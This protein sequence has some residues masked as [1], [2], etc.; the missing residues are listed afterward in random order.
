MADKIPKGK[1][2]ERHSKFDRMIH[3]LVATS[4]FVLIFTGI[5][6]MPVYKR[7]L[8]DQLPGLGWSSNYAVTVFLHYLA[9][10]ILVFAAVFHL[11][12]FIGKKDFS[13]IPRKGDFKESLIIIAAML[14]KGK[15]PENDKFLAEQRLAYAYMFLNFAVIII[16]GLVKVAKNLSGVQLPHGVLNWSTQLHNLAMVLL[17]LGIAAHLIAFVF[18]NNRPLFS[19]I[20]TGKVDLAYV[21]RRHS[22]W[23]RRLV[24]R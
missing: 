7:Y 5:G 10:M 11:V 8:V 16:T 19:S 22:L 9:A 14:G 15:E 1:K 24:D 2:I 12:Y 13:L 6:Q 3:W 20:F 18:K 23:Y 21:K 4:T 17:I